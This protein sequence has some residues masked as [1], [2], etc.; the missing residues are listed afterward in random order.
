[1][2]HTHTPKCH[3]KVSNL[4]F[5][6]LTVVA[7]L[8]YLALYNQWGKVGTRFIDLCHLVNK[9]YRLYGCLEQKSEGAQ[10]SH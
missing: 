1:M 2:F 8:I 5:K 10:K 6:K 3:N 7:T 4:H 9:N